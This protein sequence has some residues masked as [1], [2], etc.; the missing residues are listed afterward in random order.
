[1]RIVT[2]RRFLYA[3]LTIALLASLLVVV[4]R[5]H[6]ER[7]ARN[8]EITMDDAEF[9][10]FARAYG[11]DQVS[12]L[13]KLKAAGLT[14]MAIDEEQGVN[15]PGSGHATVYTGGQLIDQAKLAPLAD[16]MLADLSRQGALQA[17]TLYVMAY[18]AAT[19]RRY[20]DQFAVKFPVRNVRLLRQALPTLWAI[21]GETT[22]FQALGFGLPAERVALAHAAGLLVAPRLQN[23]RDLSDAQL[24]HLID[25]TDPDRDQTT[26]IFSG[27]QNEALGYPDHLPAVARALAMHKLHFGAIEVYDKKSIQLG[28][29]DFGR[30]IAGR[31][32]RV[33][34]ISKTEGDRLTADNEIARYLLGVRERNIRIVYIRPFARPWRGLSPPA[35]NVEIVRILGL[36]IRHAGMRLGPAIG[37]ERM[38]VSRIEIAAI[39]LAIPAIVLLMGSAIGW[40]RRSWVIALFALDVLLVGYGFLSHHDILMRKAIALL[41]GVLF[42]SAGLLAIGW[43]F[44]DHGRRHPY[45]RGIAALLIATG[46]TLAGALVVV[47]VLST[48]ATM[49]EIDRFAGVKYLLVAPALI[50]LALYFLTD[51]F[52]AKL[53]PETANETPVYVGQLVVGALIAVVGY[54]VL[55]RSGNQS[56][57]APSTFELSLRSQLT[58]ILQVRP[59]FKEVLAGFPALMLLPA[60]LPIDRRRWGWL[61]VVAIGLGLGDLVDTFSHFHTAL[62]I[63]L[64]RVMLG[65]LFGGLFGA[66]AIA[67]YRRLRR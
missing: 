10:M 66:V 25:L 41:A 6:Q 1:M 45:R 17:D 32:V 47:G 38:H 19:A 64:E 37:F 2:Y 48:P 56:D 67:V 40:E 61:F 18:D 63:G 21:K 4:R 22:A 55:E 33:Q 49:T 57:I 28:S 59:R 13:K 20:T 30:R 44:R 15:I 60:L 3:F 12:Y 9:D 46:V 52:G 5:E 65:A 39:S 34:A 62:H 27:L 53:D 42:P 8:V 35:A 24:T 14:T 26:M 51:R 31:V 50:G 7:L 23:D 58:D 36:G 43:A 54:V 29:D 16:P 11:I